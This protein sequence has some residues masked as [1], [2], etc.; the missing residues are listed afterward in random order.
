MFTITSNDFGEKSNLTELIRPK[1]LG[2]VTLIPKPRAFSMWKYRGFSARK[3]VRKA[4]ENRCW[5]TRDD[6]YSC[7]TNPHVR[8]L[9][10]MCHKIIGLIFNT[11]FAIFYY[12]FNKKSSL[13]LSLRYLIRPI[14]QQ[15]IW[16]NSTK[17]SNILNFV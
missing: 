8:Q 4:W 1:R 9:Q 14:Y 7:Y 3:T 13:H 10:W 5:S 11:Q 2:C 12:L 15:N 16:R 17:L 6:S